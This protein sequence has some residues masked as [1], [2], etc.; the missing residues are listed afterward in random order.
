MVG[1]AAS[2]AQFADVGF[3]ALIG[4]IELLRRLKNTPEQ[5]T[6][7]L[8][9]V[10]KSIQRIHAIRNAIQQPNSLFAHLSIMH[11][12]RVTASVD[13]ACQATTDLQHTLEPLFRQSNNPKGGWAKKTWRS[14]V[15]VS[16]ETDIASKITR[17][18]WLNSEIMSEMQ[19]S[20]LEMQAYVSI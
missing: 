17:I 13:D 3:R 12:Q 15:S 14:V 4:T 18:K 9:D 10:D 11:I 19:I 2:A 7:L 8:Q 20:G 5:M 6:V 1:L 16:M